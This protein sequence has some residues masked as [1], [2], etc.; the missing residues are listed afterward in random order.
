MGYKNP[1]EYR[2]AAIDFFNNGDGVFYYSGTQNRYYK[3]D[4]KTERLCVCETDGNI[5]TFL[6]MDIAS[7]IRNKKLKQLVEVTI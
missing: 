7:F 4:K 2:E 1:K 6:P 5:R 3:Y